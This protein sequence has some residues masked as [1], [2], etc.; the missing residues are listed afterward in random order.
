MTAG[1]T[2]LRSSGLPFF[3]VASTR[4]PDAAEGNL[5]RRPLI[6]FTEMMYKFLA[7]EIFYILYQEFAYCLEKL[8]Q[9]NVHIEPTLVFRHRASFI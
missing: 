7:P 6:P 1:W 5:F 3:T 9:Y 8:Y 2:F 4:S